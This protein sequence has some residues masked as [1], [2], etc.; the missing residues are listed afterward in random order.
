MKKLI[1]CRR[2]ESLWNLENKFTGWID[3][4]LTKQ[5]YSEARKCGDTLL[6]KGFEFDIAYTS[7]LERANKTLSICL[8]RMNLS[9]I[10]VIKDWRLNERHYGSLQGLNKLDTVKKYG[11][12]QVLK[13]RRSYS[14]SPPQL[15]IDHKTHP[16]NDKKYTHINK[17]V[18]SFI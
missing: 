2:S 11:D 13:W 3:V 16:S 10:K 5:G 6:K 7:I 18:A 14:T 17:N 8:E 15:N 1:I 9:K 12:N 4:P